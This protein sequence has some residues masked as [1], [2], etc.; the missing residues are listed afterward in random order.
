MESI[1]PGK[2]HEFAKRF[3]FGRGIWRGLRMCNRSARECSLT[4]TLTVRD[5]KTDRKVRLKI[6]LNEVEEF[7][8]QRR[9]MGALVALREVR[10]GYFDG[11]IYVN[12]DAYADDPVPQLMDFRASDAFAAGRSVEFEV[13][14]RPAAP[15]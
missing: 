11:L 13:V 3:R 4:L 9:P 14:E 5:A 1:T 8:F 6:R 7:R 10:F 2:I 12:L 15:K